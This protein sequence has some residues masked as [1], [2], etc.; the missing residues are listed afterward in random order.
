M[1]ERKTAARETGL[2]LVVDDGY[3]TYR[4]LLIN[5]DDRSQAHARFLGYG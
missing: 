1:T 2:A 4:Y 3:G 5:T